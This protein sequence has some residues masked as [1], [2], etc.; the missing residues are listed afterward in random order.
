MCAE[1]TRAGTDDTGNA[2]QEEKEEEGSVWR[3]AFAGPGFFWV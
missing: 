2:E 1:R 3:L